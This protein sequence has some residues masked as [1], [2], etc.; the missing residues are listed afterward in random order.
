[1]NIEQ[2]T[3]PIVAVGQVSDLWEENDV[4]IFIIDLKDYPL[5][6]ADHLNEVETVHL[7]TLQTEHFKNRY[8]ISRIVLKYLSG[9]LKKL[10]WS[11]MVTCKDK[12]GRVH[13]CDHNDLHVCISYTENIVALALSK[14]DVGID[15]EIIRPRSVTSISRSIDRSL[16][17]G[18]PSENNSDFLLMWTLKEAY[19]KLSNKTMFSNLSRKLDLSDVFHSNCIIDNKYM[20][21]VVTKADQCKVGIYR[22]QKIDMNRHDH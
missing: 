9:Y 15:M 10:S 2:F 22:L 4:L 3:P 14:I 11:D 12:H 5:A 8:I 1:M 18:S 13:V 21:A 6:D 7:D 19:C 16:P 17:D 20:L